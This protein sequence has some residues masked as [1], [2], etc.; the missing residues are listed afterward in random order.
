M[1][2]VN[3]F[4]LCLVAAA[5]FASHTPALPGYL[6]GRRI[7]A[8]FRTFRSCKALAEERRCRGPGEARGS[9]GWASQ[10][11]KDDARGTGGERSKGGKGAL[12][13]TGTSCLVQNFCVLV[14]FGNF[15]DVFEVGD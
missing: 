12:E 10:G 13:E 2:R 7:E 14:I 5:G 3:R 9:Q 6:P 15:P 11:R 1:H 8:T 4:L